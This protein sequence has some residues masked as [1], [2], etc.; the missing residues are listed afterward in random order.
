VRKQA[1]VASGNID[2]LLCVTG[3]VRSAG[4]RLDELLATESAQ[5]LATRVEV[6]HMYQRVAAAASSAETDRGE[7]FRS[8]KV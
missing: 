7:D 6:E 3:S 4:R 8:S 5:V 1:L 2:E